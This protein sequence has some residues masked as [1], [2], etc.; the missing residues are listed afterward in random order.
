MKTENEVIIDEY[1]RLESYRLFILKKLKIHK[2]LIHW[3]YRNLRR[4]IPVKLMHLLMVLN[5]I[6]LIEY[7]G[8][9]G[10]RIKGI[11]YWFNCS[12]KLEWVA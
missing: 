4:I 7:L 9:D 11:D 5:E 6:Y 12:K 3:I 8:T 1:A 10:V 2:P